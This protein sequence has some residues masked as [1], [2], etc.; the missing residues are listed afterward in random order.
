MICAVTL[1]H[2]PLHEDWA[3]VLIHPLLVLELNFQSIVDVVKVYLVEYW[4]LEIRAIQRSHL[5]QALVRFCFV[6]YRDNIVV[7]GQQQALGLTITV[8]R[9]NECWLMLPGFPLD[10]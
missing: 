8:I 9:H 2:P 6:F 3:T 4:K 7:M 10:F 5:G 1:A